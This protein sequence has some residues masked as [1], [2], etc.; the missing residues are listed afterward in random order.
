MA[1]LMVR[2]ALADEVGLIQALVQQVVDET[3]GGLWA[4]PP[5][6][7]DNEDW[8]HG[9]VATV[10]GGIAGVVLTEAE[11]IGDLW[12]LRDFRGI[13][14]GSALLQRG[15]KEIAGRHRTARLRV[16][17]SNGRAVAFYHRRGWEDARR[18]PHE[19]LPINMIEMRK[20]VGPG[21]GAN[22]GRC[23]TR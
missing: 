4:D 6:P 1:A 21:G 8:S 18:Y 9:W 10:D 7:I 15:E 3:Y 14:A 23:P 20:T 5:L 22:S 12:V 11:W 19:A 17:E 16:V 2:R 13:G